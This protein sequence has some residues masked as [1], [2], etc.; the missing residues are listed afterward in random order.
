M[1]NNVAGGS[2]HF[3]RTKNSFLIF[4]VPKKVFQNTAIMY[5]EYWILSQT[6]NVMATIM[7]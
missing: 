6:T 4:Q 2:F 5:E 7:I 3:M 1:T